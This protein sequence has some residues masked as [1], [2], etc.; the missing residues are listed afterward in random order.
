MWIGHGL[1]GHEAHTLSP[2]RFL[3]ALTAFLAVTA[4]APRPPAVGERAPDFAL[5]DQN[6]TRVR[7]SAE[8]GRKSVLV[9]YRGFW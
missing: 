8:E 3:L 9:F 4:A 5:R 7:L 6:G 1:T 2:M